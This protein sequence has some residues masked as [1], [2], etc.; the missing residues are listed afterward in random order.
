MRANSI[1][2]LLLISVTLF[3]GC[4]EAPKTHDRLAGSSRSDKNGWVYVHLQG[5][6]ADIGYQHGYL[7]SKEID[8]MLKIMNYYMP[9]ASKKDYD[10]MW[11]AEINSA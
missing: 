10:S 6:P 11:G 2:I 1:C 5:S 3:L 9:Y 7:L 4:K 8:T